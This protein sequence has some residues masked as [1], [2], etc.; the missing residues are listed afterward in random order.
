M[1][2]GKFNSG[3]DPAMDK[4]PIWGGGG[5]ETRITAG[6]MGYLA[7]ILPGI[8]DMMATKVCD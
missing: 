1:G 4:H 8:H 2:M 5:A 3:G 7:C 6:L